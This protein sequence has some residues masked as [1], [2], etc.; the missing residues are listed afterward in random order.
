MG[1]TITAL[2]ILLLET[3]KSVIEKLEHVDVYLI[4]VEMLCETNGFFSKA[5]H[6]FR[7]TKV[8]LTTSTWNLQLATV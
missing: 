8:L 7:Q 6:H 3:I 5:R 2:Y 1:E 4:V